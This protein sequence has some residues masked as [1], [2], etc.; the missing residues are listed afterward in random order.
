MG[1]VYRAHRADGQF[2]QEVAIKVL[3]GSLRSEW[4]RRRFLAEREI[5]A[6]L[7]HP[8]IARL[9]DG[10]MT[11]QQEPYLVME[12]VDGTPLDC[13][14]RQNQ[15]STRQ[16]V[17]LF[18][19]LLDAVDCAHRNLVVHRD[20]KPSNILV[21]AAGIVKL[22]D[23]GTS[24]LT[25]DDAS[26]TL[27]A[28][29]PKYASPEQSRGEP[30]TIATD[31]YSA[32]VV[33]REALGEAGLDRDLRT[34]LG[35]ATDSDAARRYG[36]AREFRDDLNRFLERQPVLARPQTVAYLIGRLIRRHPWQVAA[37]TAALIAIV[38][39]AAVSTSRSIRLARELESN[40]LTLRFLK[41]VLGQGT[42]FQL[43]RN[44]Q[45]KQRELTV[46]QA[47]QDSSRLLDE[48]RLSV[49]TELRLRYWLALIQWASGNPDDFEKHV[50]RVKQA[51]FDAESRAMADH[52]EARRAYVHQEFPV[53]IVAAQRAWEYCRTRSCDEYPIREVVLI[54]MGRIQVG[55]KQ[56]PAATATAHQAAVE[57][58]RRLGPS[59]NFTVA[60]WQEEADGLRNQGKYA[61]G[62]A[63]IRHVIAV[64]EAMPK[65]PI[66]LAYTY[67]QLAIL[68]Q[69]H[70]H[71][72][73][74][75]AAWRKA[76]EILR[77]YQ[78]PEEVRCSYIHNNYL[79]SHLRDTND[80]SVV[81]EIEEI[82]RTCKPADIT[83]ALNFAMSRAFAFR[84]TGELEKAETAAREAITITQKW[85]RGTGWQ[86]W[87]ENEL[88]LVLLAR[89]KN[90]DE[91]RK[92]FQS[93]RA[94]YLQVF[95]PTHNV[96]VERIDARLKALEELAT[97]KHQ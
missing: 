36:S 6:R 3:R 51:A 32:G 53:G 29:T 62:E 20:L 12:L 5:L 74:E 17:A 44:P 73:G 87:A 10:G 22:V 14:C 24:R 88:G 33:L 13:Y 49:Q 2:R 16:I 78:S 30:T 93:A 66:E 35:K 50:A 40:Q 90:L 81:P 42:P 91:A 1:T 11:D 83:I 47:L 92:L 48:H 55:L 27:L 60:A 85:P 56:V 79:I 28:M 80:K 86:C 15:L 39:L 34:I 31:I 59:H 26:T 8:S 77:R 46:R 52:L 71:R 45:V 38:V 58:E 41:D 69:N 82:A 7:N 21:T 37:A 25:G 95:G 9:L 75:L 54:D 65:P 18:T 94:E 96:S 76:D 84:T 23:F 97:A 4:Y 57:A 67:Q 64:E 72:E 89:G 43:D 61:E 63:I 70:P 68:N 19:Q